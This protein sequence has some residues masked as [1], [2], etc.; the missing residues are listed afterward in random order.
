MS[1][2]SEWQERYRASISSSSLVSTP[3]PIQK[4]GTDDF[5]SVSLSLPRFGCLLVE[6]LSEAFHSLVLW[7]SLASADS[8]GCILGILTCEAPLS[9]LPPLLRLKSSRVAYLVWPRFSGPA[10]H[11]LWLDGIVTYT[12]RFLVIPEVTL[13]PRRFTSKSTR[14]F[15]Q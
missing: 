9:L 8:E 5:T 1:G 4:F 14:R 10:R 12:Q 2:G 7:Q 6:T 3:T 11:Q 13:R 15:K